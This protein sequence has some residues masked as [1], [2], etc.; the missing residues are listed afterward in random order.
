[1]FDLGHYRGDLS[2]EISGNSQL[3]GADPDSTFEFK[4][5][6]CVTA[7]ASA[8]GNRD[9]ATSPLCHDMRTLGIVSTVVRR[10]TME[11]V[12]RLVPRGHSYRSASMGSRLAAF[13]A[14]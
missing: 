2:R 9:P 1:M 5:E 14:G 3:A 8:A 7:A 13:R 11:T 12:R 6:G 4:A 10:W